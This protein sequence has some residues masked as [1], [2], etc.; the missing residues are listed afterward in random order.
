[1]TPKTARL[2]ELIY[3]KLKKYRPKEIFLDKENLEEFISSLFKE[4]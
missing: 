4:N 3:E 2:V 1:M